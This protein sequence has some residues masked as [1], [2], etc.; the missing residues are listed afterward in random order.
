MYLDM[1]AEG[2]L[3][4]GKG[5]PVG[6]GGEYRGWYEGGYDRYILDTCAKCHNAVDHFIQIIL[7]NKTIIASKITE[8]TH[9][10]C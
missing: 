1:K 4:G 8:N 2:T 7:T 10:R 9:I 5:R 6:E 3:F